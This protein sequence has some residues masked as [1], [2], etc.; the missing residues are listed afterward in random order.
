MG[1]E[2]WCR[3]VAATTA[4]YSKIAQR[5]YRAGF[6]SSLMRGLSFKRAR[7]GSA[8]KKV[9]VGSGSERQRGSLV[10][11]AGSGQDRGSGPG[12]LAGGGVCGEGGVDSL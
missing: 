4:L 9:P 10:L 2:V 11:S 8:N 7:K 6:P 3:A 1:R 5:A 12:P